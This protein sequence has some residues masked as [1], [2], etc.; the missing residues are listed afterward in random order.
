VSELA[1]PCDAVVEVNERVPGHASHLVQFVDRSDPL[2][3]Q[4]KRTSL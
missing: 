3:G 2:I 4:D 1:D